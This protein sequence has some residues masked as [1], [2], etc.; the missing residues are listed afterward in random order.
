L[1]A[2]SLLGI[3]LAL[4]IDVKA[5]KNTHTREER[6]RF[7]LEDLAIPPAAIASA[8][9]AP[10]TAY[11]MVE[12][13]PDYEVAYRAA[14][15]RLLEGVPWRAADGRLVHGWAPGD[16]YVKVR[17]VGVPAALD[18]TLL[19]NIMAIH[20]RIISGPVKGTDQLLGCPDGTVHYKMQFPEGRPPL[21]TF[22][23]VEL[24]GYNGG[25]PNFVLQIYTDNSAKRCYRCGGHHLGQL[26]RQQQKTITEQGDLWARLPIPLH[27][28]P[29]P[30]PR[31]P[32]DQRP[33]RGSLQATAP[34]AGQWPAAGG[35]RPAPTTTTAPSTTTP[36]PAASSTGAMPPPAGQPASQRGRGGGRGGGG[37]G[38]R[39]KAPPDR[40]TSRGRH[41]NSTPVS[42]SPSR[43][44]KRKRRAA[45]EA[46]NASFADTGDG[47]GG[48]GSDSDT[49]IFD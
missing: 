27:T 41:R 10:I 13:Q 31:P 38:N 35:Q 16:E 3:N 42:P 2:P 5:A 49:G 24:E 44:P 47:G 34:T 1:P 39:G 33:P 22:I 21:P 9:V 23:S 30:P 18:L 36:P 37:G 45:A 46:A 11:F 7:L 28:L 25:G 26:C 4:I 29:P 14:L 12:F 8:Y 19:T 40:S 48:S 6:A 17:V 43:D 15:R 32:V 20:G